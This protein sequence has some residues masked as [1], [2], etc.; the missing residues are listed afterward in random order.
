MAKKIY[1]SKFVSSEQHEMVY[2]NK[3]FAKGSDSPALSLL[4]SIYFPM[5]MNKKKV[6]RTEF[7]S[8]LEMIGFTG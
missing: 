8:I 1:D 2:I 4:Y 6:L 3:K 7:Y 5:Q